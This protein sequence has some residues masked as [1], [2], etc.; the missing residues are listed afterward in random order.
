VAT[1]LRARLDA[2][3]PGLRPSTD[4]ASEYV[5]P[6]RSPGTKNRWSSNWLVVDD[7]VVGMGIGG[8]GGTRRPG[9]EDAVRFVTP[10]M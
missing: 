5:E 3:L 10:G 4:D 9:D 2:I 1:L 6:R 8:T 7:G